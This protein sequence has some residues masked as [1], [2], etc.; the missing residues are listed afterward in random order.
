MDPVINLTN[1]NTLLPF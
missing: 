1:C